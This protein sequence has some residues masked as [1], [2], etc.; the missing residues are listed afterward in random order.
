MFV[1]PQS[2]LESQCQHIKFSMP[3]FKI[4]IDKTSLILIWNHKRLRIPKAILRKNKTGDI[5][6]TDLKIQSKATVI[7]TI[8]YQHK[9]RHKDQWNRSERLEI[10][11]RKNLKLYLCQGCHYNTVEEGEYF[12]EYLNNFKELLKRGYPNVKEVK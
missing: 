1:L 2:N 11:P 7:K 3:F 8:S 10:N 6:L 9:D 12:K 5:T 4:R